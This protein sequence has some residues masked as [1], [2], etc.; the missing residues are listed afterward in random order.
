M[1]LRTKNDKALGIA[2]WGG[3]SP[4]VI[5]LTTIDRF[6]P[7]KQG[8]SVIT[9]EQNVIFPSGTMLGKIRKLSAKQD[10]AFFDIEVELATDFQNL[11]YVYIV[12]NKFKKEQELL[13]QSTTEV[14][15]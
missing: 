15:K 3:L 13:E 10:Q 12:N 8:D 7:I 5:N 11:S 1:T 2:K 6:K 14:K 4:R 9:S